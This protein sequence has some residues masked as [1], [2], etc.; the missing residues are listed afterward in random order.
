MDVR[1]RFPLA[2]VLS[3]SALWRARA[4][5][6]RSV[7][8]AGAVRHVTSG[9]V[10]IVHALRAMGAGP[11]TV[12]L[13][14]AYHSAAIVP[15]VLWCGATA[16]FYKVRPDTSVDLDDIAGKLAG[17]T[18][19]LVTHY[20]GF[21]QD[22]PAIRAF[23]D[24]HSLLLL[25]DCA[26]SFFGEQAG[27]PVGAFGDYAIA[28]SMKFFPIYE[29]GCIVSARHSLANLTL[30]GAG[31]GFELKSL[32]A[33]LENGFAYGRLGPLSAVLA[34]PLRLR[35]YLWNKHKRARGGASAAL[36]PSSSDSSFQ[37]EPVWIDKRA[38]LFSRLVMA[39]SS[40][41]RIVARRRGNYQRLASVLAEL[42][43]A[44]PLHATLPDGVCPWVFPMLCDDGDALAAR[45]LAARIPLLRFGAP[46]W[47]GVDAT[48][49][50]NSAALGRNVI[51]LPCHQALLDSEL[52]AIIVAL[53]E[54][55]QDRDFQ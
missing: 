23:C 45:L 25:E 12:V 36:A 15:P 13:L 55:L 4:P 11:G 35:N 30:H 37:L 20:F 10:A 39:L 7:L 50:S 38:S 48:T 44:R 28:S 53:R 2:P 33:A 9:R 49:C 52:D 24:A 47:P 3:G 26:H 29:G 21:L 17:A 46:A 42:R 14:P 6:P 51:A 18:V 19:L 40:T 8:Q 31:M 34:L 16:V 5:Q 41:R 22:M 43:G 27:R 32:L 54:A 1:P